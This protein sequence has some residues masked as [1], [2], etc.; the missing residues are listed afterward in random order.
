MFS[1]DL[2]LLE[3]ALETL[4]TMLTRVSGLDKWELFHDLF[5]HL[6]KL[7]DTEMAK[8]AGK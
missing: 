1:G 8:E 2:C 3:S 4:E 5:I 6:C 7:L